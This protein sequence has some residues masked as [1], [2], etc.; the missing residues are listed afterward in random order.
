MRSIRDLLALRA[1]QL[2]HRDKD[3]KKAVAR[4]ERLRKNVKEYF[5]DSYTLRGIKIVKGMLVLLYDF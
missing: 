2:E 3:L 1:L 5:D 4:I